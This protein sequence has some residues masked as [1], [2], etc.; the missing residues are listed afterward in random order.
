MAKKK[1]TATAVATASRKP[2]AKRPAASRQATAE[3]A[4]K[5]ST[6]KVGVKAKNPVGRP[7]GSG[8]KVPTVRL[9]EKQQ[10]TLKAVADAGDAGYSVYSKT[11]ARSLDALKTKKLLKTGAKDKA[12][13]I[14]P[15]QITKAGTKALEGADL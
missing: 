3:T 5:T 9:T 14:V 13:G 11:E 10:A 12:T 2:K 7:K 8:K 1:A 15:Y 4:V 6:P